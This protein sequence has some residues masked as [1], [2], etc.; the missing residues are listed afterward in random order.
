LGSA[1]DA[2]RSEIVLAIGVPNHPSYPSN[3]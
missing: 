2:G 1:A 3:A